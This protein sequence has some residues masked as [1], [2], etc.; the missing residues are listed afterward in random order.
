M[1][2]NMVHNGQKKTPVHV[3]LSETVYD[4]CRS[5]ELIQIMNRMGLNSGLAQRIFE[6]ASIHRVP[7]PPSIEHDVL[8]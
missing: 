8:I 6:K 1:I 2:F 3:G 5:K 7:V 4:I